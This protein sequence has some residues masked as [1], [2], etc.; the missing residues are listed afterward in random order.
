MS[1][2]FRVFLEM[3]YGWGSFRLILCLS[4][5]LPVTA[6][7]SLQ[8]GENDDP[9]EGFNRKAHVFNQTLDKNLLRPLAMT[10]ARNMPERL[11]FVISNVAENLSTPGDVVNNL[12]QADLES[13]FK[14]IV[15]FSLNSTLGLGGSVRLAEA[16]NIQGKAGDFGQTLNAWG[17]QEGPYVVLPFLGPSTG[18][19]TF[20]T[21]GDL[22][23][24]PMGSVLNAEALAFTY[25]VKVADVLGNR[26]QFAEMFDSVLYGSAD[27]YEQAKLIY[28]QA[29]RFELNGSQEKD[30]FDPYDEIFEE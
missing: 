11:Q 30:Y 23:I 24:D 19:D 29:R 28:L 10:Y 20:G 15:K 26:A 17:A 4:L 7:S 16:L 14:N 22:T 2:K 21:L 25:G 13:G 12:L 1:V 18:R 9:F 27:S 3:I 5:F 8:Q 6:C